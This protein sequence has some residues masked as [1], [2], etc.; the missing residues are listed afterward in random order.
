M[1]AHTRRVYKIHIQYPSSLLNHIPEF[2]I[3]ILND[4]SRQ[5]IQVIIIFMK[6]LKSA[7][8]NTV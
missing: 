1:N 5:K 3:Q 2:A 4:G 8:K 7:I 6:M